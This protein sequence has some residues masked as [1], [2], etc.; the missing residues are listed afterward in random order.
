[1]RELG[2]KGGLVSPQTKLRKAA[3]DDLRE[4]A[5]EVLARA[6]R[7]EEVPKAALDSARSLYSFRAESPPLRDPELGEYDGPLMPDA[8][9]PI[10][11]GD[12][13]EFAMTANESTR[14][15]AEAAIAQAQVAAEATPPK[16]SEES[17]FPPPSR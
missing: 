4:Q 17:R 7:G 10:G 8:R 1:M 12:V 15:V 3:D 11:L 16:V 5:R 13:L 9:R 6:L 14:A 2:W